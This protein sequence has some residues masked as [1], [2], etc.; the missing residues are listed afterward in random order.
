MNT[1]YS[2]GGCVL[3]TN[4]VCPLCGSDIYG[5]K[6]GADFKCTN[7]KCILNKTTGWRLRNAIDKVCGEL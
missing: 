7:E 5:F 4:P 2:H 1:G 3:K 6:R